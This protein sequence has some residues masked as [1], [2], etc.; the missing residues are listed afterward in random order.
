[1]YSNSTETSILLAVEGLSYTGAIEERP[2]LSLT[3]ALLVATD[4]VEGEPEC[5]FGFE[6]DVCHWFRQALRGG[7]IRAHFDVSRISGTDDA[8]RVTTLGV[9]PT[10]GARKVWRSGVSIGGETS[11]GYGSVVGIRCPGADDCDA[12]GAHGLWPRI[13]VDA[14]H[15]W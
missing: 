13:A 8:V 7:Y 15:A 4:S 2:T 1:M 12:S 11:V 10:L 5:G 14:G 6:L 3:G 9:G